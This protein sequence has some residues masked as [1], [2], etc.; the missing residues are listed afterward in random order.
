M[1]INEKQIA[2]NTKKRQAF[3]PKCTCAR[4]LQAQVKSPVSGKG[5]HRFC[6]AFS[7]KGN[8]LSVLEKKRQTS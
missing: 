3:K 2:Q 6:Q 4:A 5:L 8:F 7:A 1:F